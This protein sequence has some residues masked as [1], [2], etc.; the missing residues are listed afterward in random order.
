MRLSIDKEQFLKALNIASKAIASKSADPLLANLKL[1]LNERGLEVTGTNKEITIQSLVPYRIGD[2]EIIRSAGLGAALI[3][4]KLL[5]EAVR[6]MGGS[7]LSLEIIDD[8]IAKID[9]G[10]SSFKLN[11][12]RA[13][14]FT[15][16]DLE[17]SGTIFTVPCDEFSALVDSS[18]FA[19]SNKEQRPILTALNLEASEGTLVATA[20][21]SA[22]LARATLEIDSDARFRCNV[23]ARVLTDVTHLFEGAKKVT[24]AVSDSS[25]L[26]LFDNTVVCSRLISGDY[27]VTKTII[28]Q[29]YNYYLEVN[30]Q[31]LLSA[32]SRASLLSAEHDYVVKLSM[33]EEEVEVTARSEQSGSALETIQ[34]F[35]FTGERL[36][37]SFNS[38][39]LVDAIKALKA[40][41][42]RL[43]FQG[44]MRPFVVVNPKNDSVVELITPMRTY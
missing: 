5:T 35:Q 2:K 22:R 28:P 42:V 32:I 37:V 14:A 3:N 17:P 18:A 38:L 30:A 34:T 7:E 31:E 21:D 20:T 15:D 8:S 13:E 40:E 43:C 39:F 23:P 9:D 16:I 12:V 11:C 36:D 25:I 41:D 4:A 44:E 24:I 29:T 10:P 1:D 6:R 19:A 27:P 26:F 33:S